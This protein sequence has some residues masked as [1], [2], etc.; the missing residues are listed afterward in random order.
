MTLS[1]IDSELKINALLL[2]N[3][4]LKRNPFQQMQMDLFPCFYLPFQKKLVTLIKRFSLET[5]T[6]SYGK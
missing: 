5:I 1:T 3:I 4:Q 6:I 2:F